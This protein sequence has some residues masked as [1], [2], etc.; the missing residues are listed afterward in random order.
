[1]ALRIVCLLT[2]LLPAFGFGQNTAPSSTPTD[3]ERR[4]QSPLY[5]SDQD[6][7]LAQLNLRTRFNPSGGSSEISLNQSGG[8]NNLRYV[9]LGNSNNARLRQIG[10]NNELELQLLGNDN[11]YELS[12]LGNNNTLK[13]VEPR[14]N[15][16]FSLTQTGNGN[17]LEQTFL[18]SGRG[19]PMQ[20][21]QSGGMRLIITHGY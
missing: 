6:F 8:N 19:V 4:Q 2:L 10:N 21:E 16:G 15:V 20:I 5:F 14:S 1:M 18:P 7:F 3:Q 12:Q 13:I 17:V 11:A 9:D